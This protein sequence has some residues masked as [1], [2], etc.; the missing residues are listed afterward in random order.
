MRNACS[1]CAIRSKALCSALPHSAL[2]VLNRMS[3]RK[4]VYAGRAL[5]AEEEATTVV[6]TIISGVAK[7]S[8]SLSDGRTQVVALYF[9]SDF[10][11]RPF[12]GSIAPLTEA[13]TD[14]ELCYFDRNRFEA[15]LREHRGLEELFVRR[16]TQELDA[17][18]D[19]MLLLGHKTAEERV[20]S[21]LML[22]LDKLRAEP[23]ELS[24]QRRPSMPEPAN[25]ELEL[26]L[27]RTEMAEFLGM[28]IETVSRM[29][30]RLSVSGLIS[31]GTG[32]TITILDRN[33]LAR[34]AEWNTH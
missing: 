2:D 12:A 8:I 19:W 17:S 11:G 25:L 22:C 27:S 31:V 20:A 34:L 5:F 3:H 10:I 28:T 15:L 32:R 30:K 18:R 13:A 4:R 9:P 33:E 7:A 29:L 21:L 26:P 24:D 1:T 6:A 14:I 16:M 23:C